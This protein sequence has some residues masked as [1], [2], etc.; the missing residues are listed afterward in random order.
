VGGGLDAAHTTYHTRGRTLI[1]E[2]TLTQRLSAG[3][4][5][6][7]SSLVEQA[8]YSDTLRHLVMRELE[9]RLVAQI[10]AKA[11]PRRP[12]H[13]LAD[14][15]DIMRALLH[16]VDRALERRLISQPVLH[17]LLSSFLGNAV[18]VQDGSAE[19]ARRNFAERHGHRAPPTV[20]V[21]SPTKA[22]NLHCVG[23]YA[24]SGSEVE[25]LEWDVFDR[26]LSEAKEL[27][28][29]RFFTI[30]GG[31][32]LVYRSHGKGLLDMVAKHHDCFFQVYTNGTLISEAVAQRLADLGN[33][34]P[35]ISVE[36]FRQRTDERRGDGVF[37]RILAAMA[38][39]RQA[40]APFGISLTATRHNAEEILSDEF[41]DFFF[42]EQGAIFGWLFQYMP[43]GRSYT[44]DLLV[45]PEQR[46]WMWRRTWQIIRERKIMM[47]DFW[48]CGT[49]S[50]GCIA[51]GRSSGYLYID[52]NGKIMPCVFVPYAAA[53][54]HDIYRKGGTLDDIYSLPYLQAIRQWQDQYGFETGRPHDTGNWLIP[55]SLRDHYDAGRELIDRY[56]PEPEDEAAA[57]AL[58]DPQYREGMLA[59]DEKL[60]ELLDPVWKQEYLGMATAR[61]E[62]GKREPAGE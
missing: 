30:S 16:S 14:K 42:E 56:K 27:W 25:Q 17:R 32:P 7:T 28:G 62:L 26:L 48:N 24:S 41:L 3:T 37:D 51:A 35:T 4:I 29:M 52:W 31:E 6:F 47:A 53:N 44:L 11:D 49:T 22:C 34:V 5:S 9:R 20:I 50:D 61:A 36:G 40:G 12:A 23:C 19:V 15:L 18:L 55:C 60:R 43:I 39:L 33:V 45:T 38:N 54:I 10:K 21:I 13:V 57:E 58:Q 8:L 1:N 46:L 2:E 59:Y